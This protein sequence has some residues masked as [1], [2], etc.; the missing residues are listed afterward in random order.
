MTRV[1]DL[2]LPRE[3]LPEPL[4]NA[5]RLFG[6]NWEPKRSHS[7]KLWAIY[8]FPVTLKKWTLHADADPEEVVKWL[9]LM[10]RGE[11]AP[12]GKLLFSESVPRTL[13]ERVGV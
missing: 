1:R 8:K 9:T 7:G 6:Y 11:W 10:E 12:E 2:K 3:K 5:L 13:A 4:T